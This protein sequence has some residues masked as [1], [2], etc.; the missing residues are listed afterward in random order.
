MMARA[1]TPFSPAIPRSRQC[2]ILAATNMQFSTKSQVERIPGEAPV[3]LRVGQIL[4][5][6]GVSD[7]PYWVWCGSYRL[8]VKACIFLTYRKKC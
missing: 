1:Q 6:Q 7:R 5:C 3:T 4:N 2:A 8:T